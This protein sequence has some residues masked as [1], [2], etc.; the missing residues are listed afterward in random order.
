MAKAEAIPNLPVIARART[1]CTDP[2]KIIVQG[3]IISITTIIVMIMMLRMKSEMKT[4]MMS[5]D[6][7]PIQKVKKKRIE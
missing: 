6:D 2:G 1:P 3:T 7:S 5:N 4:A